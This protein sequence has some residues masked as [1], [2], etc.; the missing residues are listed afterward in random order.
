M[1]LSPGVKD[2]D[3]FLNPG[4]VDHVRKLMAGTS[5]LV[6][7][8]VRWQDITLDSAEVM[9][10]VN[11]KGLNSHGGTHYGGTKKV[12]FTATIRPATMPLSD[13]LGNTESI[14]LD[15]ASPWRKLTIK[16]KNR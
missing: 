3:L 7:A 5:V 9:Q 11:A 6:E 10:D 12:R 13:V 4:V 16:L 2:S 1:T 14:P 15:G 8:Y